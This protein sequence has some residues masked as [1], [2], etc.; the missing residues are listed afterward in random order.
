MFDDFFSR[1]ARQSDP[2]L[3][4]PKTKALI[5]LAVDLANNGDRYP[6]TLF[7]SI[8]RAVRQG[9]TPQEIR[10]LLLLLCVYL[11]FNRVAGSFGILNNNLQQHDRKNM[12]SAIK[13]KDY[14]IR[15]RQGKVAFY[16]LLKKRQG[17]N[18]ELF[19]DYWK[20]VRGPVCARLPGQYQYWQLHLEPNRSGLWHQTS[21]VEYIC[22]DDRQYD[23]I[24]ELTFPTETDRQQFLKSSKILMADEK[25][26]FSKAIVYQTAIDNS[27]TY[28][29]LMP[30]GDPNG[31]GSSIKF[32]I[33]IQQ[34]ERV[35]SN[36]FR[37][38]LRNFA[39]IT[40]Q[41]NLVLKL[42]L[43]L[44]E[45]LDNSR[46]S[47]SRVSYYEPPE[48]QYQAAI[49]I[50]FADRLKMEQF[51]ASEQYTIATQ[52]LPQYVK[53]FYPF[54][55]QSAYTFV[56]EGKLTL[57]G[58]RSA[59]VAE[60][61][62]RAGA[63][64]Q[65]QP[66]I[67]STFSDAELE[68]SS[69][70]DNSGLGRYL[71][72][73]QHFGVTVRDMAQSVEFYTQVLGGQLVVS[74]EELVG[75]TVQNTLFQKEE[76]D[77]I[78]KGLAS[79]NADIP[80]LRSTKDDALDVKFISFGNVVVELIY[81]RQ[82][83]IANPHESSVATLPSHIGRV[84]AM[85]LSF[86]LKEDLDLNQFALMLEAECHRRG[87]NE[88]IF[89]RVKRVNSLAERKALALKHNSF[90]FW[91]EGEDNSVDWSKDPMEGWSLFY[92]K[93]PNGEQLEFNQVT[94]GVKQ[95]FRRGV[96]KYNQTNGTA[97]VFPDFSLASAEGKS[98]GQ[99]SISLDFTFSS[100][101]AAPFATVWDI[102]IDK[103]E[104]TS[105]YNPEAKNTQILERYS[106]GLIRQM[107]A[108]GMTVK[109]RIVIDSSTG[110]ITHHLLDN[111]YF[112][113]KIVNR[114]TRD[115]DLQNV[116]YTLSWQPFNTAGQELAEKISDKLRQAVRMA[117]LS[118]K[119][120]A[121]Q[122]TTT[123]MERKMT[124][125]EKLPGQ[126]ADLV[127]RLFSRGEAFDSEGF[128]TF[129]TDNPVYQF[130]NF[131]VCLDKQSIK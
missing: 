116:S 124:S 63:T 107:D 3:I 44:F 9:V 92:C 110:T 4:N 98:S 109:E 32:H 24:A 35:S 94:R 113:G 49:E 7:N 72:G 2:S 83:G 22:P 85:H 71:Q 50:A 20:N 41:S 17:I 91:N 121:E 120:A 111:P 12:M 39:E 125:L 36:N 57:A 14:A 79:D 122:L 101:V 29:D 87:M 100:R 102:V 108:L 27:R 64:N 129:F 123:T 54:P 30:V 16:V 105:R 60:L 77:A 75:D 69:K 53:K 34:A 43:H 26:L 10:E 42:R 76:L 97:F 78:A 37:Q 67:V 15:D 47:T 103:I 90:K 13:P 68:S 11:G 65:L 46:S 115:R 48:Q 33:L 55:E 89:N 61:I 52:N 19:Y 25:N 62:T 80:N 96:Q 127:K 95:R 86:N 93:G 40:S 56:Y 112:T 117:V 38:Y 1:V 81:F 82:A 106:D 66:E 6:D 21:D 99:T 88:V 84:N 51:L 59:N 5:A 128:V 119:E 126:N 45:P 74:E 70:S 73:V 18:R 130:G 28:T 8:E 131:D 58:Q 23:G 114:V 104:N 118:A 31:E